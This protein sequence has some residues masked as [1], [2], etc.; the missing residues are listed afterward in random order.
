LVD[1]GVATAPWFDAK[2][3]RPD[4]VV[5]TPEYLPVE[6][7]SAAPDAATPAVDVYALGVTLYECL[8]G[9]VPFAG[10]PMQVMAKT[11]MSPP[12]PVQKV[13]P[14]V[15]SIVAT[16]V[17]VAMSR[18]KSRRYRDARVM[19]DAI[20]VA[21]TELSRK[22]VT[23]PSIAPNGVSRRRAMRAPYI[24]PVRVDFAGGSHDG[25]TEDLSEGG[26]MVMLSDVLPSGTQVQVRFAMPMTGEL[27]KAAAVVRWAKRRDVASRAPCAVGLEFVGL[28][29]GVRAAIAQFVHIIGQEVERK[30]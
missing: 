3:T 22:K 12:P 20:D 26:A 24:T 1:L 10:N 14:D 30:G 27:L 5:G 25:R 2:L 21:I 29:P 15:P 6:S 11:M 16:I 4:G 7:I 19:G 17:D 9:D 8:T 23:A 28:E 13:R 18:D